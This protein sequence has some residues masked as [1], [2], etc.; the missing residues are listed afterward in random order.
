MPSKPAARRHASG[1]GGAKRLPSP[2]DFAGPPDAAT[3]RRWADA[4]H[5]AR[6]GRL[7][8]LRERLAG[9]GID[10]YFGVRPE[11]MRWLTGFMLAEGEEKSA[12][13]SGQFLAALDALTVLADSRYTI[14]ARR[15][16][17]DAAVEDVGSDLPG[18]WPG[19]LA[20]AGVRRVA[21]E[22][23]AVSHA[24]WCRLEAAAPDV[25]LVPVEG[26][27]EGMRATKT[28]DEVERIEAACAVADRAL[29]ALLPEIRTGISESAL[30]LRLE[31]LIRTGGAEALAFDVACL[32][33]PEA[34][35][36][37]GA[38]GDRSILPGAV[39]LFD[40]GAQVEGYR[41]DMTRTLFVGEPAARDLALYELVARAQAA[42][43]GTLE[44][45]VA[46]S[47]ATGDPLPSG[48]AVDAAAREVIEAAG[49]G[50][51]FG[52]GTGHGIGLAT[53]EEPRLSRVAPDTPLPS[54]TVF[55]VEPGVYLEGETGIRIE[56]L[57]LVDAAAGRVARLTR[58]PREVLAVGT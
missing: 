25:E 54:P 12:G 51:R 31:W 27:L 15:E 21:V 5:A 32:A 33:G 42:A 49:L 10:A 58:F 44:V 40:F 26:W 6:P 28:P 16:A 7:H 52:H 19:L 46:S 37:H 48:R 36:P 18:R 4:D 56:D 43:I 35:L 38:P 39:L 22:A 53:H 13:H 47:H 50:A 29:A 14:Q 17:P 20:R 34:A 2:G 1:A 9:E 23:G 11:H 3:R 8:A 30:A 55:S 45:S 41:S 57:V 24:L